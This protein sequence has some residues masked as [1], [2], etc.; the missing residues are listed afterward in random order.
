MVKIIDAFIFYN[1]IELLKYRLEILYLYVDYFIIVESSHTFMGYEKKSYYLENKELFT[2][3]EDKIIHIF[4]KDFPF[5]QPNVNIYE[6]HQWY[7]E[8]YQ[9]N[10]MK[11][12]IDK[13]LNEE[14]INNEDYLIFSDIDEIVDPER[15]KEIK[16]TQNLNKIK[17]SKFEQDLYYY[18]LRTKYCS[19]W[20]RVKILTFEKFKE[21]YEIYG[22]ATIENI[23]NEIVVDDVIVKGGW[24]LSFFGNKEF[25]QNKIKNFS[26]QELNN[27]FFTN[28]EYIQK[29][30]N[31][32]SDLFSR[33]I[34]FYK[35]NIHENDY[36]PP[37]YKTLLHH[38]L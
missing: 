6:A 33:N 31:E 11:R 21:L 32:Q 28:E 15:L 18:N 29:Q 22:N 5:I 19:K 9:R 7:N 3:Y 8:R 20:Y 30:I 38:F 34:T 13:L 27:S 24:H 16:Y 25:I 37:F 1:E 17:I 14:K 10:E 4:I 26:H 36:L 2:K 35:I 12:G 23:R